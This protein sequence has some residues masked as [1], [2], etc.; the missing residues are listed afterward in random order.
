MRRF[1]RLYLGTLSFFERL[2]LRAPCVFESL[3]LLF[4]NGG[5]GTSGR[6]GFLLAHLVAV[7]VEID[8]PVD[9]DDLFDLFFLVDDARLVLILFYVRAQVVGVEGSGIRLEIESAVGDQAVED[10]AGIFVLRPLLDEELSALGGERVVAASAAACVFGVTVVRGDEPLFFESFELIVKSGLFEFVLP[11]A[12]S[13]DLFQDVVAVPVLAPKRAEDY[14][15]DIPA[16]EVAVDRGNIHIR[17]PE[18]FYGNYSGLLY[19]SQYCKVVTAQ[20]KFVFCN[21]M[22]K[23]GV[24][25]GERG[26]R[27]SPRPLRESGARLWRLPFFCRSRWRRNAFWWC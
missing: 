11:L 14:G 21:K 3:E 9:I 20:I 17:T 25:R 18:V 4:G 12:A 23:S 16:D 8:L 15:G 1:E 5:R 27:L 6:L 19:K 13:L 10:G 2:Y 24:R 26:G 7:G 22:A